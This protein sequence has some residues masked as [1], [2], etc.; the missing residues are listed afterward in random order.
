MA[1][2]VLLYHIKW[3][4]GVEFHSLTP[5]IYQ[6]TVWMTVFFV[7]SGFIMY[8]IYNDQDIFEGKRL[9]R[10]WKKRFM[11]L[12]PLYMI[13]WAFMYILFTKEISFNDIYTLPVQLFMLQSFGIYNY[14]ISTGLW[15]V[16][17]IFFCYLLCPLVIGGVSSLQKKNKVFLLIVL[18]AL[19]FSFP[20][21]GINYG[22][23]IYTNV[24]CRMVEFTFGALLSDY[25]IKS[26]L[27]EKESKSPICSILHL[28]CWGLL[29]SGIIILYNLFPQ[30]DGYPYYFNGYSLIISSLLIIASIM[31]HSKIIMAIS[32]TRVVSY[33]SDCTL[34]FWIAS[35]FSIQAMHKVIILILPQWHKNILIMVITIVLNI[36]ITIPLHSVKKYFYKRTDEI[37][38]V[39]IIA[40]SALLLVSLFIV[41]GL[42]FKGYY[43]E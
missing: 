29:F 8:Y 11:S 6:S 34:E 26:R 16:S 31:D 27:I 33:L 28:F 38:I 17:C 37:S 9:I 39:K 21:V 3:N 1:F 5:I 32:K 18:V 30:F 15:F 40:I 23:N 22:I 36:L 2:L 41:K 35:F 4:L 13:V 7:L 25:V 42:V 24:I 20:F 43:L 10:F 12:F 19:Q 14:F